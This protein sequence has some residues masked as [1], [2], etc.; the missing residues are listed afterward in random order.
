MSFKEWIAKFE[1]VDRPIGDLAKDV[2]RDSKFPDGFNN[3]EQIISYLEQEKQADSVVIEVFKDVWK[4][5]KML[6]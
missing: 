1:D 5:Y 6:I 3:Q 4:A 2:L